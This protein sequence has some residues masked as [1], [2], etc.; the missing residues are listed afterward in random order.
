MEEEEEEVNNSKHQ[1]WWTCD[2]PVWKKSETYFS[3]L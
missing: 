2:F 3:R 1:K